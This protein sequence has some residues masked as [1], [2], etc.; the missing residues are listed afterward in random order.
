MLH[1]RINYAKFEKMVIYLYDRNLLTLSLLDYIA[2]HYRQLGVDSAGSCSIHAQDGRD[3]CQ[4]CIA[5]VDPSFPIAITGS[6]DDH[7]EYWE[8]ELKK[9]EEIVH[10]RWSWRTFR[11]E[12]PDH[13]GK[14]HE[15]LLTSSTFSR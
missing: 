3:L 14:S 9:W 8:R 7:D 12:H 6:S 15:E 13:P 4:V 5:L 2:D 1:R 11:I 10:E